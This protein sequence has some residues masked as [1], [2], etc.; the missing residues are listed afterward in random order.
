MKHFLLLV[1]LAATSW[2]VVATRHYRAESQR[3][4][5]N[6]TALALRSDTLRNR[7]G[8]KAA[9]VQVL[10]LRMAEFE[11]L[12]AEDAARIRA[13]GLRIRDIEAAANAVAATRIDAPIPLRDTVV[14]RLRDT[15]IVRDT[16]RMFRWQDAWVTLQGE[17]GPD[18]VRCRVQC[19]D[20][21]RQ[22]VYR[23][24]RR[25]LF[26]RWGTKALRQQ[27]ASSNPHTRIV[28]SEYV[29]IER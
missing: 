12:R 9:E 25:F 18:S 20:T 15:L 24:P 26:I 3:L 6:Q 8:E 23:I 4:R 10:R 28:A 5:Q 13:L 16:V 11:R 27:I 2:A 22:I 21:L 14:L 1:A 29:R 7:L 17:I 19:V